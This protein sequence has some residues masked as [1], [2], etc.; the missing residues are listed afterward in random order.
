[1]SIK[2][3]KVI[4]IFAPKLEIQYISEINKSNSSH[5]IKVIKN[6]L[7]TDDLLRKNK[8]KVVYFDANN[9]HYS[10]K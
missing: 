5:I 7:K 4:N 3:E 9:E 10:L 2:K 8:C 6:A 1:M